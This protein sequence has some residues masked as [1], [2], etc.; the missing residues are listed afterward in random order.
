MAAYMTIS[1]RYPS[2]KEFYLSKK[3]GTDGLLK[4]TMEF[5]DSL[6][7]DSFSM[8]YAEDQLKF[9]E[10]V[11][12]YQGEYF[13]LL[14][15]GGNRVNL[16]HNCF[17]ANAKGDGGH[18]V[19]GVLGNKWT[20]PFK[21]VNSEQAVKHRAPPRVTRSEERKETFAPSMKDFAKCKSADEFRDSEA[22]TEGIGD[23][24]EILGKLPS[25]CFIHRSIF[26]I[27]GKGGSMRAGDLAM[28]ALENFAD[29]SKDESEEEEEE[30]EGEDGDP[31]KRKQLLLFL[32]SVE[33]KRMNKVSLSEPPD[34]EIF[35]TL[36]RFTMKKL[37]EE[38]TST[39]ET[40]I[41]EGWNNFADFVPPPKIH[42]PSSRN[43]SQSRSRSTSPIGRPLFKNSERTDRIKSQKPTHDSPDGSPLAKFLRSRNA[44]RER[45]GG[46]GRHEPSP[47]PSPSGS[48]SDS[49]DSNKRD[50]EEDREPTPPRA[51]SSKSPRRSRSKSE[52]KSPSRSRSGSARTK[53]I[54]S[55][56]EGEPPPRKVRKSKKSKNN[57]SP[58]GS[59]S[60]SSSSGS[61]SNSSSDS[62]DRPRRPVQK[63]RRRKRRK[64]Q[65]RRRR[66]RGRDSASSDEERNLHKAMV[67]SLEA[68]TSSQLK[69][70]EKEDKKKSMLSRLSPEG[71]AL[72]KL[73]SA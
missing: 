38:L 47:S 6:V 46:K 61:S 62:D 43:S 22:E 4:K 18:F 54:R 10:I 30:G 20:S 7:D 33:N 31:L 12:K 72:F 14:P 55:D 17:R 5:E 53:S 63:K 60:D 32:W 34:N 13:L 70:D 2:W 24:A 40:P 49:S 51:P 58:P 9:G 36:A 73:L 16:V 21:Q 1:S 35:D 39:R 57:R 42:H 11:D 15:A 23:S 64:R 50:K 3:K 67:R 52:G 8:D 29:S 26:K 44:R 25:S 45:R 48:D 68:M 37:G 27:F 69:R 19:F 71:G 28:K 56:D 41:K 66:A 59:S 65:P